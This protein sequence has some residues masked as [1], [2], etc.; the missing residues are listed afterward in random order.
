M[1]AQRR[2][3]KRLRLIFSE[4]N[5]GL[6]RFLTGSTPLEARFVY[7]T[8]TG[9]KMPKFYFLSLSKDKISAYNVAPRL[10]S[11]NK[12][13]VLGRSD[14]AGRQTPSALCF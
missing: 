3:A 12:N 7:F 2:R 14:V 6:F 13:I 1:T 11:G 8:Q 5:Y 9:P 4:I 10:G